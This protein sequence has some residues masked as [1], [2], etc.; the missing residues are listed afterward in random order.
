[1]AS[2]TGLPAP[3]P[4][5][6]TE[7]VVSWA[8][9]GSLGG[10]ASADPGRG[11]E[12]RSPAALRRPAEISVARMPNPSSRKR[13][14]EVWSKVPDETY[15]PRRDGDHRHGHP[16]PNPRGPATPSGRSG[17]G[18]IRRSVG[19]LVLDDV[20]GQVLDDVGGQVVVD[21]RGQRVLHGVHEP[22]GA[23]P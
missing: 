12:V 13:I 19:R 14:W 9:E 23:G 17:A 11:V 10:L 7:V 15:P 16:D 21:V 22:L 5:A 8:V 6:S 1:M 18:R 20:G 4:M 3:P 2:T